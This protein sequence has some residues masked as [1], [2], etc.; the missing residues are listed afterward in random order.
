M[1]SLDRGRIMT[2]GQIQT[3]HLQA[4][5]HIGEERRLALSCPSVCSN[6][7]ARPPL[8]RFPWNFVLRTFMKLC[9]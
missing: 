2:N 9:R 5:S 6:V 8:K 7:S 3:I 4:H 1:L